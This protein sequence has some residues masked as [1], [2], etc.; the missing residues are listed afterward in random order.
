M[1][2]MST[3][4]RRDRRAAAPG[5]VL[6]AVVLASWT[7]ALVASLLGW[8]PQAGRQEAPA[9]GP[10]SEDR[11]VVV[12][13]VSGLTWSHVEEGMPR[14][15]ELADRSGVAA[16][17]ARGLREVTCPADA[18]LTLGAGQRAGTD[19]P[20][21][22]DGDPEPAL[23]NDR[24]ADRVVAGPGIDP[25]VW[26]SWEDLGRGSALSPRIGTLADLAAA[27]GTC[28]AWEGPLA[29]IGAADSTGLLHGTEEACRITFVALPA[30]DPQSRGDLDRA[31]AAAAGQLG[32]GDSL[33]VAGT[34]HTV[35]EAASLALLIHGD[36]VDGPAVLT[37]GT[38]R[39]SG[40]VQLTDLT[41]TVLELAGLAPPPTGTGHPVA[42]Q[43]IATA[44]RSEAAVAQAASLAAGISA[45]KAST[46]TIAAVVAAV[47]L[48]PVSV[49]GVLW[50]RG[51]RRPGRAG[52][53][54]RALVA[55]G[56]A[57]AMALP[58]A[59]YLAGVV[60]WWRFGGAPAGAGVV[61]GGAVVI[62]AT[63]LL[64]GRGRVA[65]LVPALIAA[66]TLVVIGVD[67]IW[68]ARLGLTSV[69]GLQPVT[70]GRFYG[71]GNVGFGIVLGALVVLLA[72][73]LSWLPRGRSAAT[74]VAVLG[75]AV[76]LH[77][78]A[79]QIGADFGGVPALVVLVGL[80]T[81]TT[82]GWH[83]R[84]VPAL[85][86]LIAG[87]LVAALLMVLD[88]LRGP[89]RRTHLGEFVQTALDGHA[90]DVVGRKLGQSLTI[91]VTYPLSWL[92][93]LALLAAAWLAL[94][95]TTSRAP[96]LASL[97]GHT[98]VL[99]AFRAGLVAVVLAWVLNDSGIAAAAAALT[100]MVSAALVVL[101]S[102]PPGQRCPSGPT[103]HG[104]S[105]VPADR[106]G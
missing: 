71:Q 7:V 99:P 98:G 22:G 40:L 51:R 94:P 93:V 79:P 81:V 10:T 84:P 66:L 47:V 13:G 12:L 24:L 74:L 104:G 4:A 52:D 100:V 50:G 65:L 44:E 90:L 54:G 88:F 86:I 105:P 37:S 3:P 41:P 34:G 30:V 68:S 89:E 48:I 18:W 20:G 91:L 69:V 76:V 55:I 45:A 49:G 96:A 78:G 73:L 77:N 46:P 83:W 9:T 59:A 17:V 11:S 106:T 39:Q 57:V 23:T 29:A 53:V 72:A 27:G 95:G 35:D 80:L 6:V 26:Q 63:C 36:T 60:P 102:A 42:G 25:R 28:V 14:T 103:P 67:V 33:V 62:A 31:V 97:W 75:G 1:T 43:P 32:E 61:V 64:V 21:C 70:A 8:A 56:A 82:L 5:R 16:L 92:A 58:V 19:V 85:G 38:T 87:S 15:A 2:D 101:A